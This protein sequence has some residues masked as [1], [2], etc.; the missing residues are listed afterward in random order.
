[1]PTDIVASKIAE[2]LKLGPIAMVDLVLNP[3]DNPSAHE[4]VLA[5]M[6]AP[7][8]FRLIASPSLL[9]GLAADDVIELAPEEPRGCRLLERSGNV[10]VQLCLDKP[11]DHV[12]RSLLPFVKAANGWLD[13]KL[14]APAAQML[15]FTFPASTRPDQL[16]EVRAVAEAAFPGCRWCYGNV[17]APSGNAPAPA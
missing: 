17:T 2:L 10:C 12:E 8:R 11:C 7:N 3:E 9:L 6:L 5:V 4:S 1:M 15:V 14:D 13:G 16:E